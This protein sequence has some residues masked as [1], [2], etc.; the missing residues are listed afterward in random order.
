MDRYGTEI[1]FSI[2]SPMG[3]DGKAD[4]V[5]G[6]HLPLVPV[7]GVRLTF[8]VQIVD[9]IE[10]P[11]GKSMRGRGLNEIAGVL[12]LRQRQGGHGIIVTIKEVEHFREGIFILCRVLEGRQFQTALGNGGGRITDSSNSTG[13]AARLEAGRQ[14]DNGTV[15]HA[16]EQVIGLCIKKNGS[17]YRIGTEI[18]MGDPAQAGLDPAQDNGTG[19]LEIGPDEI[20]VDNGCPIGAAVVYI[21]RRIVV[22]FA[23]PTR[24][25]IVGHHGID[26]AAGHAPEESGFSQPADIVARGRVWLGNNAHSV[27]G[28]EEDLSDDGH[29]DEGRVNVAV[30]GYQD[31]IEPVP[32]KLFY[33]I[34]CGGKKHRDCPVIREPRNGSDAT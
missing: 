30:A 33:F 22:T 27:T 18:V 32:S 2:T 19:F 16:I 5:H 6:L 17:S 12:F 14:F 20:A 13:G 4:G 8:I 25:G 23:L 1:T 31:D 26:A 28:I 7:I 15:R 24:G 34:A 3:C 11:D 10:L 9:G 21:S 29:A